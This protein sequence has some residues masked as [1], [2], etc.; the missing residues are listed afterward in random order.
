MVKE[1]NHPNVGITLD[2]GHAY[3]SP[4]TTAR[5]CAKASPPSRRLSGI[6]TST[7][8][9]AAAAT[10]TKRKHKRDGGDGRGDMHMPIGWGEVPA[11]EIFARL[12][13]YSWLVTLELRPRYR[14]SYREALGAAHRILLFKER[15]AS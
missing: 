15:C 8:T 9:S 1:V 11:R 12:K 7:T 3:L 4:A 5:T 2:I 13:N 14:D 6:S 10:R